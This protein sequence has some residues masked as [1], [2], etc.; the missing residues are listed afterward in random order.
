[1]ATTAVPTTIP[2]TTGP[3]APGP[4]VTTF[5][6][7]GL[8][9]CNP[10][11]IYITTHGEQLNLGFTVDPIE[12]SIGIIGAADEGATLTNGIID[13]TVGIGA[14]DE[15]ILP[16]IV[17]GTIG[18]PWVK[19]SKIGDLDF[20]I[21]ESN[22]AGRRPLDWR[23]EVYHILKLRN[24][25]VVYGENGVSFITPTGLNMALDTVQRVGVKNKGAVVGTEFEHYYVNNLGELWKVSE[26]GFSKLDFSEYLSQMDTVILSLDL[27]SGLLYICDG[28]SGYV[29]NT[30]EGSM[31][32]GPVN[33]TGVD[34][35]S[36]TLL[37]VADGEIETPKFEI[38]TDTYDFGTRKDKTIYSLEVGTDMKEFLRSS[39]DFKTSNRKDWQ[40]I[41]WYLVNPDGM[42]YPKCFGVEF[43]F[44]LKAYTY[45]YFEIDYIKINGVIHGYSQ[46]DDPTP[47]YSVKRGV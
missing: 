14:G 19:W 37:S 12:I 43:R 18:Y 22:I 46:L 20:T 45:E 47:Y 21:D 6:N 31:G 42:S 38:L 40:R 10:I 34:K 5:I 26:N 7:N 44:R 9:R 11:N 3:P 8:V 32:E 29:Y 17:L 35:L 13:V 30:Y 4:S 23:G 1:M 25:M 27:L 33:I 2:P 28:V 16:D 39:V 24:R 15:A 36:G 41:G